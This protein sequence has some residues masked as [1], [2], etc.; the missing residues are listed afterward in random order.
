[1]NDY[2]L[3]N[4]SCYFSD[5]LEKIIYRDGIPGAL[6]K[7][8]A[9][10]L[11]SERVSKPALPEPYV[12]TFPEEQEVTFADCIKKAILQNYVN[13]VEKMNPERITDVLHQEEVITDGEM[14]AMDNPGMERRR[15]NRMVIHKVRQNPTSHYGPFV[16]GLRWA[17]QSFLADQLN[18]D[19][20]EIVSVCIFLVQIDVLSSCRPDEND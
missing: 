19:I 8:V 11:E 2:H 6:R 5:K 12:G 20:Q 10:I 14:E 16:K 17:G 4:Y 15:K 18:L 3:Q 1:M 9:K 13:L 7:E